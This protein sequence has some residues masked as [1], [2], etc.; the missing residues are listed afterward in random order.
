MLMISSLSP[1]LGKRRMSDD[2]ADASHHAPELEAFR[3]ELLK[4]AQFI[5]GSREDAEDCVQETLLEAAQQ[6]RSSGSMITW[7][8]AINR[9]NAID[10]LRSRQSRMRK[11]ES[12]R[13]A[14]PEDTFTTGG[15]SRLELRDS[16]ERSIAALPEEMQRAVRLRYYEHLSYKQIAE[17][18][19]MPIGTV[20]GVLMDAFAMMYARLSEHLSVNAVSSRRLS[21]SETQRSPIIEDDNKTE[22]SK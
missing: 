20:S 9:A 13:S 7:L 1:V 14:Q 16:L 8:R 19:N 21:E 22:P 6:K 18:L 3:A 5:L 10:A 4:Q 15:F 11:T 17:R 2:P 12:R